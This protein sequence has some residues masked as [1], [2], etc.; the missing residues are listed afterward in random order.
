MPVVATLTDSEI[1]DPQRRRLLFSGDLFVYTPRA[2]TQELA[3]VVGEILE[4]AF[5][6]D[7][8]A[9]QQRMSEAEFVACFRRAVRQLG[10]VGLQLACAVVKDLGCDPATTF[11]RAP[12]LSASTGQGF[13]AHGL[14]IPHNPHR[15]TWFA[16]AA[17]QLNWW[18]PLFDLDASASLA[19]H[20]LYWDSPVGNNSRG[21]RFED[22]DES[23]R[24]ASWRSTE[25]RLLQ[26]RP[27]APIE[28]MPQIRFCCPAGGLIVSSA[29]QLSSTVPNETSKTHFSIRFQTVSEVDLASGLGASN[30][31]ADPDGTALSAF[32]RCSDL[33]PIPPDLIEWERCR[34][35][36]ELRR[37]A[38]L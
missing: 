28:L 4:R 10:P 20:P 5:G 17:C 35:R 23:A 11:L 31:D 2:V 9:A 8:V 36:A 19:F 22:W 1:T 30:M 6:P 15:D 34:R 3:A 13:L 16:A 7:P 27:T 26:P 29:A 33:S 18:L 25:D 12:S 32:V 24:T 38:R 14:G 37:R 21:F